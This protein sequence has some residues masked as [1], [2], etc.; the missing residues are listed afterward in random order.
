MVIVPESDAQPP[1]GALDK[2]ETSLVYKRMTEVFEGFPSENDKKDYVR[3]VNAAIN[4]NSGSPV[5][6]KVICTNFGFNPH[7]ANDYG[8]VLAKKHATTF[9]VEQLG[10][11]G[12]SLRA[13][14]DMDIEKFKAQLGDECEPLIRGRSSYYF[15]PAQ[16]IVALDFRATLPLPGALQRFVDSKDF[17]L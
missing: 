15:T 13:I 8:L 3:A 11:S 1:V 7:R 5:P 6:Y 2:I 16:W 14:R 4:L 17:R 10:L 12:V 9:F